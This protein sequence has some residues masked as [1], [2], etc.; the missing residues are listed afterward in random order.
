MSLKVAI[1]GAVAAACV[2]GAAFV[3][4]GMT[5]E[6]LVEL[7]KSY[8]DN[9]EDVL[10]ELGPVK[11]PLLLF[12]I[13]VISTV[14]MLP[15]WG[16]HM[17]TGYVYGTFYAA[18]LIATTQALAAGAAFS[19]SRYVV[20]PYVRGF[21]ERKYGK[22]FDAIDRAVSNEGL[23][24]TLLLRLSPLIPFG[25]NNYLCGITQMKLWKF[26]VGTWLGV[27]PGTTAY[28]N[29][30]A[31][32][33]TALDKGTTPLQKGVM[34]LGL[35]AGLAVVKILS[36]V[37]SKALKDAGIDDEKEQGSKG[38]SISTDKSDSRKRQ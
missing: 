29:V 24:I 21:L 28:C 18:L 22:K 37:S 14:F 35:V 25:M 8:M 38:E 16:F 31:M 3:Q 9:L 26:V 15:L 20:G 32:G 12:V 34:A 36:D 23:K 1:L 19:M 33:K 2:G 27:L 17:T 5:V 4:S 30:G 10:G 13:Y 7:G 6:E 11:G